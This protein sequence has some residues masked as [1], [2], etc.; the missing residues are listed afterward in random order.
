MHFHELLLH[1]HCCVLDVHVAIFRW[2]VHCDETT[3]I[4]LVH[5]IVVRVPIWWDVNDDRSLALVLVLHWL[6]VDVDVENV[7]HNDEPTAFVSV[8]HS[9]LAKIGCHCD[10]NHIDTTVVSNHS[11]TSSK[12]RILLKVN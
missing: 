2:N 8:Q 5:S 9:I 7:R 6:V 10:Q 1:L 12:N 4:V 11:S 3:A